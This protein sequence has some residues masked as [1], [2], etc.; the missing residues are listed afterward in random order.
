[1]LTRRGQTVMILKE[2]DDKGPDLAALEALL[3]LPI[4]TRQRTAI[5]RE[6]RNIRKGASGE[7]EAAYY[8]DHFFRDAKNTVVIHDLRIEVDGFVAQI[9]HL[10]LTRFHAAY[11]LETKN[12]SG[13]LKQTEDGSWVVWYGSTPHSI[14]SPI[15]Q[16]RRHVDTLRRWFA[17]VSLTVIK[18]IEPV[19]VVK[20]EN[21]VA[22]KRVSGDEAVPFVKADMIR[23]WWEEQRD[24]GSGIIPFWR[25]VTGMPLDDLV[26]IGEALVAEHRPLE[27][28]WRARFGI[29]PGL[30]SAPAAVLG[31]SHKNSEP[32]LEE[33]DPS[34]LDQVSAVRLEPAPVSRSSPVADGETT[35]IEAPPEAAISTGSALCDTGT[36]E[37]GTVAASAPVPGQRTAW[38]AGAPESCE[39]PHGVVT[40]RRVPDGRYAILHE[41]N[42]ALAEHVAQT[43]RGYAHWQP[44]YRNWLVLPDQIGTVRGLLGGADPP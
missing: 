43:V 31:V 16:A 18:Q 32:S 25:V 42:E 2:I 27:R 24:I 30:E 28:D 20:P 41:A 37:T 3:T 26:R 15:E 40:I 1:M 11:V 21:Y 36:R 10:L 14:A 44:R 33:P 4:V 9:D 5:E 29:P 13:K 22:N 34:A 17:S 38:R 39:T 23:K 7:R 12:Y 6:I 19:I 35:E 8:L